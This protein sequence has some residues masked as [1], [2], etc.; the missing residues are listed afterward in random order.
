MS[1][2]LNKLIRVIG[3]KLPRFSMSS[4]VRHRK[5]DLMI[6]AVRW[7]VSLLVAVIFA[8]CETTR[9]ST[10]PAVG[11]VPAISVGLSNG[12]LQ[13]ICAQKTIVYNQQGNKVGEKLRDGFCAGYLQ[14]TFHA[15]RNSSQI[16]CGSD[17][18]EEKSA[19]YLYS[20]YETYITDKKVSQSESASITLLESYRRA[21]DCK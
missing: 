5:G 12:E 8:G 1:N 7:G 9:I 11:V 18:K 15:F 2:A 3:K 10:I 20:I 19:E 4:G 21:F 16:I 6:R 17:S 14:A 13:K